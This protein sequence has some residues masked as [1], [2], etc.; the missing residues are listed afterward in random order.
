MTRYE[1]EEK[2]LQRFDTV[3]DA[4]EHASKNMDCST[5]KKACYILKDTK[6][7]FVA[8]PLQLCSFLHMKG[9]K[10]ILGPFDISDVI[11][12]EVKLEDVLYDVIEE[13]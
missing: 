13:S 12:G 10:E 6:K 3:E 11:R 9:Y 5:A 4:I 7:K 2:K 1:Q 8:A